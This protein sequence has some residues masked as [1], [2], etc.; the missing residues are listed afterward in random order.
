MTLKVEATLDPNKVRIIGRIDTR[1][2][3]ELVRDSLNGIPT[4]HRHAPI[5][6]PDLC[7]NYHK[8]AYGYNESY[9]VVVSDVAFEIGIGA[10]I[11]FSVSASPTGRLD[12]PLG[13]REPS[14]PMQELG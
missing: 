13:S 6:S 11:C 1:Q 14:P 5:S 2:E 9:L 4:D 12:K 8:C 7:T 3:L 10:M